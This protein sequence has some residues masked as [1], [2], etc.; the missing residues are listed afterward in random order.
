MLPGR[1]DMH[2]SGVTSAEAKLPDAVALAHAA[3]LLD[4][5]QDVPAQYSTKA[6][7]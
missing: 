4:V 6:Q 5:G 7:A 2:V 1:K 3:L